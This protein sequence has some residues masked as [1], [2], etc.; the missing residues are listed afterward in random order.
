[1]S[2]SRSRRIGK[3]LADV[4][5]DTQ[6]GIQVWTVNESDI[7]RLKGMF[8]GPPDTAYE[9]GYYTVDVEIPIGMNIE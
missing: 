2:D 5:R 9:G 7:S 6:A 1:M 3:E 4:R 8:K